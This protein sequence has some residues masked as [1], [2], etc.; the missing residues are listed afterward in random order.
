MVLLFTLP[1]ASIT[2]NEP[3]TSAT[4]LK[5][6]TGE[7]CFKADAEKRRIGDLEGTT[8]DLLQLH[9]LDA[10]QVRTQ[11]RSSTSAEKNK[12]KNSKFCVQSKL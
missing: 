8:G 3:L 9:H 4:L 2:Q 6:G 1:D 7:V 10:R 5:C 11:I 12:Q